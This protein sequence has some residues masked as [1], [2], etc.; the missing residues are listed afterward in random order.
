MSRGFIYVAS[1]SK[2]YHDHALASIISLKKLWP[3]AKVCL[4]THKQWFD[5]DKEIVNK[6]VDDLFTGIPVFVRTKLWALPRTP[7][8]ETCYIDAD[9]YILSEDI[10]YIFDQ[11]PYDKHVVMTCNRDYSAI[12]MYFTED[13]TEGP[14]KAGRCLNHNNIEDLKLIK[15]GK[16][17]KLKW[18]CGL[19]VYKNNE[20][21]QRLWKLWL[22][23]LLKHYYGKNQDYRGGTGRECFGDI[24]PYPREL[25]FW[26]TFA[27]WRVLHENADMSN[28]VTK[29]P[30]P[31]ARWQWIMGYREWELQGT[32]I[33]VWHNSIKEEIRRRGYLKEN[34]ISLD[35]GDINVLR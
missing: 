9:T 24:A 7:Y 13:G 29:F 3:E 34:D 35:W 1:L 4:F 31:D 2:C 11:R 30:M 6:Y 26:D 22:D 5:E 28:I 12:V 8:D 19:F 16:A 10:K 20:I 14:N 21:T 17:H 18:H 23:T 15:A 27:F 32:E 25:G 33:V